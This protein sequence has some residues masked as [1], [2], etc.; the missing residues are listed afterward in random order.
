[1][2]Q[3]DLTIKRLESMTVTRFYGDRVHRSPICEV[4]ENRLLIRLV[5]TDQK[6][7][8]STI[9]DYPGGRNGT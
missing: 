3:Q 5:N 6:L 4:P 2:N 7:P 1:M 8:K 9:N